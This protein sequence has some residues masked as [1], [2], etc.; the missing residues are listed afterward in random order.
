VRA[1]AAEA[2]ELFSTGPLAVP[3]LQQRCAHA[4]THDLIPLIQQ[5]IADLPFIEPAT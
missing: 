1:H 5:V 4:L 2:I 3:T